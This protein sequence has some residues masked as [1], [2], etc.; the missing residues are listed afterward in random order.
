[1]ATERD[2]HFAGAYFQLAH[3]HD[4]IY[5]IGSDHTPARLSLAEA[6][7]EK[8]RRIAPDSAE[9][10]LA[11]AKH[12]YWCYRDYDKARQELAAI[13]D[14]LPNNPWPA[15]IAGY[16]E[17]RQSRW[18]DSTRHLEYALTL[19][20]RNFSILTQIA[21]TY[22]NLRRY[23]DAIGMV[24]RA[25]SIAPTDVPTVIFRATLEMELR[26]DLAPFRAAIKKI[27]TEK[28]DARSTIATEWLTLSGR[29]RD[30]QEA[31]RALAALPPDGCRDETFL[32]P[33]GWCEGRV[34]VLAGD[35][36]AA[37]KAFAGGRDA[38]AKVAQEQPNYAEGLCILAVLDAATGHKQEAIDEA[39]RALK[40]VPLDKDS[41]VGA[42]L[43]YYLA[44][45]YS[46]CGEKDLAFEQLK[47]SAHVPCGISYD[48]LL[49]EPIWDDLRSD[50]RFNELLGLLVPQK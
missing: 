5:F 32:F 29:E 19:D 20:P 43:I 4:Q 21:I 6:A 18:D 12:V 10:H 44:L 17:R 13:G 30:P 35:G 1:M 37:Q 9:L 49:Y 26:G 34:A 46:S 24:N 7:I 8:L 39:T 42:R 36:Q 16:M 28:P 45:V 40:M 25:L 11:R 3:A 48:D 23:A 41:L 2:P 22:E 15:V 27:L 14:R 50:P 47:R 33:R 38:A 31:K